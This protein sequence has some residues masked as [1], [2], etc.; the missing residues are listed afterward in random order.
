MK[1]RVA[2]LLLAMSVQAWAGP[3]Y[4][5]DDPVPTDMRHWEIYSFVGGEGH[6][7]AFDGSAGFDLNY[8][9]AKDVQ[10]TATLPFTV[11]RGQRLTL[12]GGDVELGA[13]LRLVDG[14]SFALAVFPRVILP[15]GGG[16][17]GALFPVWAQQNFGETSLFGGGGYALS[18]DREG[19]DHWFGAVAVTQEMNERLSLGL[20][21][22]HSGRDAPD[23]RATS[24]LGFGGVDKLD[25]HFALLASGGPAFEDGSHMVRFHAY[26]ALGVTF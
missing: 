21:V 14:G 7:R 9:L 4:D 22:T 23:T 11:T 3:P 10:L 15:T 2:S 16:R 12:R 18:P 24:T 19:R 26:L 6:A 13:K 1:F 25:N 17:T 5:T 20:E 8:G